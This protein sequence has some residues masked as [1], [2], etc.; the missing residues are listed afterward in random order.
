[1]DEHPATKS[2]KI[3]RYRDGAVEEV[4]D[5]LV[6]EDPLE[7]RVRGE[8]VAVTM[9]TPG[10]DY[11]LAAGF[12]CTEAV[13]TRTADVLAIN[14]CQ[15]GEAA[16]TGNVVNVYVSPK[17]ELDLEKLTRHVFASSSCGLC[18]KATIDAVQQQFPKIEDAPP[19][20]AELIASLPQ[21][22]REAQDV[23]SSTGGLHAAALFDLNGELIVLR[24]DVGRH[25]AV[26]KVIG[27]GFLAGEFPCTENILLVSGRASFEI[28]QKALAAQISI[29]AAV[30]APSSLAV[31][32]AR[33][34]GQ[35][36]IGFLR[37]G[38]MNVYTGDVK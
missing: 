13:I 27:H 14:H 28:M 24:E 36:M 25:N 11:E 26:D 34:N 19:V 4:E 30:S 9:R 12:L 35:T 38:R 20:S 6:V 23:F 5:V 37:E 33:E 8:A 17:L 1:M 22:L 18:G 21:K 3:T 15:I 32:F 31:D 7:I 10:H 16:D 29:I 2:L